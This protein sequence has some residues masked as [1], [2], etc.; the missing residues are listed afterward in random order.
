MSTS[1]TATSSQS[2]PRAEDT[3]EVPAVAPAAAAEGPRAGVWRWL[4]RVP[5]GSTAALQ[6]EL[7]QSVHTGRGPDT[8]LLLEHDPVITLGRSAVAAHVLHAPEVLGAR[9]I[10]VHQASRGGDVTYHGPG[11][12]VGYPVIRL[13]AGVRAHVEGMAAA[14]IEVLAEWGVPARYRSDAPGLWVATPGAPG[15]E[16]KICAFG[17]NVRHRIAI[18][19]FALNLRP[20]LDAFRL[21]VPC[22]LAGVAVTSVQA[23]R[24]DA[25][26]PSE[27]AAHAAR[28]LGE[29]LG[30]AFTRA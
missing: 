27:I 11:Q 9:G 1:S 22:G 5:F 26:A 16:A 21:I 28:A 13:R 7:R 18:H 23:L 19:G 15:G 10:E 8:L 24:G 25:P 12:L 3:S 2:S 29:R 30:Y 6:E 17:V 14:L 20:D 4:G